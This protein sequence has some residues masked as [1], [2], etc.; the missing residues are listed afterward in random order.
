MKW[1][2]LISLSFPAYANQR[3]YERNCTKCHNVNPSL[4]GTTGPELV[5]TP[6][7]VYKVKIVHGSYPSGYK[8]KRRSKAMPKFKLY[9]WQIKSLYW[10]IQ[11]FKPIES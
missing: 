1:L 10:Y 2:L 11:F 6:E 4:A 5:T 9:D 8:A 3:M 7:R